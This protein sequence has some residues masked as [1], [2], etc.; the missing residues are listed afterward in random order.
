M[1]F[2]TYLFFWRGGRGWQAL[3]AGSMPTY[4]EKMRV[5]VDDGSMPT[6]EEKMRVPVD[7]GSV[8]TYEET[9]RV[10]PPPW[11]VTS[12]RSINGF[13]HFY[14]LRMRQV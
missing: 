11:V 9:M 10:P 1:V 4:E 5:P 12:L 3:D 6:Y 13:K 7:D 2:L 8:P 14:K